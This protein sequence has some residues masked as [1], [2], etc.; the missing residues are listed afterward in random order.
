MSIEKPTERLYRPLHTAAQFNSVKVA[1][2]FSI[3]YCLKFLHY[4]QLLIE[5]GADVEPANGISE[6]P[7]HVAALY[8]SEGVAEVKCFRATFSTV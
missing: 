1:K 8:N 4:L 5:S 2:V 3:L 6:H 7:L